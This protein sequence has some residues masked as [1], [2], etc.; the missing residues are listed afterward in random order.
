M[1]YTARY[2]AEQS[3]WEGKTAVFTGAWLPLAYKDSDAEFDLGFAYACA[4]IKPPGV[5][6]AMNG[7]CFDANNVTK[8][9]GRMCFEPLPHPPGD[10]RGQTDL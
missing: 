10:R 1:E 9:W 3:T 8:N 5:Y 6:V 4:K 2:F 7:E